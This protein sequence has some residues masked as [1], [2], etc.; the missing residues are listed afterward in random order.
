MA[1][2]LAKRH[3]EQ[4]FYRQ[5]DLDSSVVTVALRPPLPFGTGF[6]VMS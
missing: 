5:A 2:D 4:H 1:T 6:Q 3:P